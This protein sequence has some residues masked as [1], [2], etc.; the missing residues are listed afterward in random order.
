MSKET[1]SDVNKDCDPV[2]AAR[3][4][5]DFLLTFNGVHAK[6]EVFGFLCVLRI[7]VRLF[8]HVFVIIHYTSPSK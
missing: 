2:T 6:V 8:P 1:S 4:K 5:A 7:I 3:D